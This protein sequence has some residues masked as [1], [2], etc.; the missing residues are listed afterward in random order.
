MEMVFQLVAGYMD[1]LSETRRH[2]EKTRAMQALMRAKFPAELA[3]RAVE[4][5]EK[6]PETTEIILANYRSALN[7]GLLIFACGCL[8]SLVVYLAAN[9]GRELVFFQL[10]FAVGLAYTCNALLSM[11][12]LKYPALRSNLIHY[13]FLSFASL[14][15]LGYVIWGIYF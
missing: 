2:S 8:I 4:F 13:A 11:A 12:G 6:S 1:E 3:A 7:R 5:A 9:P 10:P 15:I 14:L